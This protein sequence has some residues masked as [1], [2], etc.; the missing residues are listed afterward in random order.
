MVLHDPRCRFPRCCDLAERLGAAVVTDLD[1]MLAY[2][3]DQ[4]LLTPDGDPL[5]VVRARSTEDVVATLQIAHRRGVPVVTRGAGTG[6]A[7][8]RTPSTGA[9]C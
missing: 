2:R 7:G 5:A 3:R 4:S 6:L 8:G 9:S 1:Q